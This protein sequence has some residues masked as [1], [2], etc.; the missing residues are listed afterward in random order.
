[1][2]SISEYLITWNGTYILDPFLWSN[3][4]ELND[5]DKIIS[6]MCL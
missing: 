1:M 5:S 2:P 4:P 3:E 6:R